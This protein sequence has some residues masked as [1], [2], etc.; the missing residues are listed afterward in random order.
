M[1]GTRHA[2]RTGR[3]TDRWRLTLAVACAGLLLTGMVII[4]D[5]RVSAR[6]SSLIAARSS[7][8]PISWLAM[9]DSYSSGEGDPGTDPRDG[10]QRAD[11][12]GPRGRAWPVVARD[13]V[14]TS[15]LEVSRFDFVAC[16]G[17]RAE[18]W[19]AQFA[20]TGS[21]R[22]D[23]VTFTFGGNNLG[24]ADVLMGCIGATVGGAVTAAGSLPLT[25][26]GWDA[27]WQGCSI[28]EAELRARIDKWAGRP[29]G[30]TYDTGLALHDLLSQVSDNA[31]TTGGKLVVVGYP[32][33]F[34]ESGRWGSWSNRCERVRRSDAN[35]LR[36]VLSDLDQTIHSAVD[37]LSGKHNG[38]QIS[39][40]DAGPV[41]EG[42]DGRH[43][44]C[45]AA[46]WINGLTAITTGR[47]QRAFH[48]TLDG[49]AHLGDAVARTVTHLDF[50]T[51][52]PCDST[53]LFQAA[54]QREGFT[55]DDPGYH[56]SWNPDGPGAT[57]DRCI[58]D[59]ALASISRPNVG[60]TDGL[61]LFHW[62]DGHWTDVSTGMGPPN[63]ACQLVAEGAPTDI[64]AALLPPAEETDGV[65]PSCE[66]TPPSPGEAPTPA[67]GP[68]PSTGRG[69]SATVPV[70]G[71]PFGPNQKGFGQARPSEF[72][73]GGSTS[74]SVDAIT[75][76]DW[77]GPNAHG[78]GTSRSDQ[79]ERP[80]DIVALD[81]GDCHGTLAYRRLAWYFP[82]AGE[83]FNPDD[84]WNICDG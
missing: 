4:R 67:P 31:V 51:L 46:P 63:G 84:S 34:E 43:G 44:L 24:F 22:A 20:S 83:T 60:P 21:R 81:L 61:T 26:V 11:G 78:H 62:V 35:M 33:L 73:G 59:W 49:H 52:R 30:S 42:P 72:Y 1:A 69:P 19:R 8:S 71:R 48:P 6:T 47:Y 70:L 56:T 50:S 53:L 23:L 29:S 12:T 68:T 27:P 13:Q 75:W 14:V 80:A 36:G 16:S 57:I 74:D 3:P 82:S 37:E 64:A 2:V 65:D 54:A 25:F 39:F 76:D 15:G 58:G 38:V 5:G 32:Q 10:C 77:G 66:S 41:F 55:A 18:D 28:P 40:V 17:N 9:G 45:S 79:G 7:S